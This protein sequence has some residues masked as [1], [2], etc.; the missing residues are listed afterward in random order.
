[1]GE[2]FIPTIVLDK[3][4]EIET[5]YDAYL[6]AR[7]EGYKRVANKYLR[8]YHKA[9]KELNALYRQYPQKTLAQITEEVRHRLLHEAEK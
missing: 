6:E 5:L 8:Q 2:I 9:I 7:Y 1:M 3:Q 4:A